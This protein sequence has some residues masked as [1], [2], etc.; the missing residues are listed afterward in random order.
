M[1]CIVNFQDVRVSGG[2]SFEITATGWTS[3]EIIE[4]IKSGS[5]AMPFMIDGGPIY[6]D[7]KIIA[8]I[9][10]VLPKIDFSV[11]EMSFEKNQKIPYFFGFEDKDEVLTYFLDDDNWLKSK[12]IL[13][14]AKHMEN[15]GY[16][17]L[18]VIVKDEKDALWYL[19]IEDTIRTRN[20]PN[21]FYSDS[22]IKINN[23]KDKSYLLGH[24]LSFT[25]EYSEVLKKILTPS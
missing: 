11:S 18:L 14:A 23:N 22:F 20:G 1:H 2:L 10:K 12:E 5:A 16:G 9:S 19:H 3:E 6:C 21:K 8:K 24:N 4:A 25:R 15:D 17:N 13:L 7:G